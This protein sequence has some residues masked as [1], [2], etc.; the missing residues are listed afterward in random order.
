LIISPTDVIIGSSVHLFAVLSAYYLAKYHKARFLMEVRDLWPQTL[1]DIGALSE[2]SIFAKIMYALEKFLYKRAEKI[3]TL[4]PSANNYINKLGID[5]SKIFWIP[6]GVDLLKF[7]GYN[8]KS[9]DNDINSKGRKT[10][11]ILD[12]NHRKR[13]VEP[14]IRISCELTEKLNDIYIKSIEYSS[15]IKKTTRKKNLIVNGIK[16]LLQLAQPEE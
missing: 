11:E 13:L 1:I 16:S 3:I 4:L 10:V 9:K 15:D 5:D 2:K 7:N 12:L 6:N 8:I 14:R